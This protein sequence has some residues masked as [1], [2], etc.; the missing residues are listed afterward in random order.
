MSDNQTSPLLNPPKEP[1]AEWVKVI[2]CLSWALP[3]FAALM[4][5]GGGI[6]ALEAMNERAAILGILGGVTS[7]AGVIFTGWASRIRDGRLA[8]A[9]AVGELGIDIAQRTQSLIPP[10]YGW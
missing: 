7:A 1:P 8:V 9:H 5:V 6:A 3:S 2:D 4:S 10:G